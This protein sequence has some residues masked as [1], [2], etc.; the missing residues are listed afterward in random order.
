MWS[1][2]FILVFVVLYCWIGVYQP[3][4]QIKKSSFSEKRKWVKR[5]K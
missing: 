3:A 2:V 4:Q 5:L 1:I